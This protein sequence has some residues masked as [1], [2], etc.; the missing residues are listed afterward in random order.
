MTYLNHQGRDELINLASQI[1]YDG[2]NIAVV[3]YENPIRRFMSESPSVGR[4][5][6]VL[7]ATAWGVCDYPLLPRD[8]GAARTANQVHAVN[9]I[10][11]IFS[12][13][14]LQ[15]HGVATGNGKLVLRIH[16]KHKQ[17]QR[18]EKA[19]FWL[20]QRYDISGGFTFRG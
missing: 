8:G 17:S 12:L 9:L 11:I 1:G 16:E 5:L 10:E 20:R 3:F 18:I 6:E 19:L 13:A 14:P 7:R 4:R 2:K 15:L